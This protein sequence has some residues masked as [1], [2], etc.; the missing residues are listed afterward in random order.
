MQFVRPIVI[1]EGYSTIHD[2]QVPWLPRPNTRS[3]SP[4]S[5]QVVRKLRNAANEVQRIGSQIGG[6]SIACAPPIY[7]IKIDVIQIQE[8][9]VNQTRGHACGTLGSS[10]ARKFWRF[11]VSIRPYCFRVSRLP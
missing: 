3:S 4:P 7:A 6:I 8:E 11:S 10:K 2:E 5:V 9:F 1:G